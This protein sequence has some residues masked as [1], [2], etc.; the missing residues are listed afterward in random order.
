MRTSNAS[1]A[2][3]PPPWINEGFATFCE[4]CDRDAQGH[5]RHG[6]LNGRVWMARAR[7]QAGRLEPLRGFLRDEALSAPG[8]DHSRAFS[9]Y[10]HARGVLPDVLAAWGQGGADTSAEEILQRVLG[11]DV[12]S[13][14]TDFHR[15]LLGLTEA[16]IQI[17]PDP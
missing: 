14:E 1:L 10:L 16:D 6:L 12:G 4:G 8:W 13:V 9:C 15:W 11:A 7:L 17:V 5:V 3:A 2:R